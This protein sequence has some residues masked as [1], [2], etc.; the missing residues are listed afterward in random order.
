MVQ[1]RMFLCS[2]LGALLVIGSI[3]RWVDHVAATPSPMN[4]GQMTVASV[5]MEP[6]LSDGQIVRVNLSAYGGTQSPQRG[7]IIAF[8]LAPGGAPHRR[9]ISRVIGLP[10]ESVSVQAGAV[11][12]NGEPL[13]EPYV[14]ENANYSFGPL[15]VPPGKYFVLGDNRGS[16]YDSHSWTTP[17]LAREHIIGRIEAPIGSLSEQ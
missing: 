14:H 10:G 1:R 5:S 15:S 13:D 16:S 2:G 7:D 4:P 8:W 17:W 9:R 3:A 6:T 12:I 11:Y